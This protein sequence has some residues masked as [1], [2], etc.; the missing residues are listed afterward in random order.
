M[1]MQLLGFFFYRIGIFR[2]RF[3]GRSFYSLPEIELFAS[4]ASAE[5]DRFY[6]WEDSPEAEALDALVQEWNFQLAYL[7]P[8]PPILHHI[9]Q[10][11]AQSPGLFLLVALFWP[12]RAWFPALLALDIVDIFQLLMTPQELDLSTALPPLPHLTL[13]VWHIDA[14]FRLVSGSWHCTTE[15]R[16]EAVWRSIKAFLSANG[17]FL[18]QFESG[19]VSSPLY[20]TSVQNGCSPLFCSFCHSPPYRWTC[21]VLSHYLS[22]HLWHF[23]AKSSRTALLPFMGRRFGVCR[24]LIST[25]SVGLCHL[26]TQGGVSPGNGFLLSPIGDSVSLRQFILSSHKQ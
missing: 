10:K 12:A 25:T 16:Y 3:F 2:Q 18:R 22:S 5:V 1:P 11:I 13:L 20:W 6:A 26:S 7:F 9:I 19:Q 8:P 24:P 15:D 14:S 23:S 21:G 17:L 4:T